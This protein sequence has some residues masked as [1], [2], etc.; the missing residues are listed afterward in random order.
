MTLGELLR[1]LHFLA[2]G[3]HRGAELDEEM[4]LHTELRARQLAV[5]G[6][7]AGHAA[8]E[9]ER[10]FG[11]RTLLRE[12]SREM[13]SFL[14]IDT[15][16]RELRLAARTLGRSPGFTLIA[17]ITLALGIGANT[18]VFSVV[19]VVLLRPLP[20]PHPEQL[21]AMMSRYDEHGQTGDDDVVD[22]RTWEL[23]R[24]HAVAVDPAIYSMSGTVNLAANGHAGYVT[25]QRVSAGFFR[26]LGVRPRLG[27]EFS[28]AED[29]PG[30]PPVVILSDRIWRTMLHADPSV[31]DRPVMLNGEPATVTGIMPPHFQSTFEADVWAPLRAT[32]Q[33]EGAGEN[34]GLVLRLKS[35]S[36]WKRAATE[37]EVIGAMRIRERRLPPGVTLSFSLVPLRKLL[38]G[39]VRTPLLILWSAVGIVL[40]IGCI[41]VAGLLLARGAG[42]AREMGTRMALGG[43]RAQ[44]VRQ[45]LVES[46]LLALLGGATGLG[47]GWAAITSFRTVVHDS[48]GIWQPIS[49]DVRVLA[50]TLALAVLT[51]VLF[52]LYP[53]FQASR[54]DIRGAL[55]E[56]GAR[57]IAGGRSLW[58]RRLMI[59]GEVALGVILLVGAGLLVRSFLYLRGQ[60]LGFDPRSL[61]A[62]TLPMQDAHYHTSAAVNHLFMETLAR[63]R[64]VPGVEGAAAV[65]ALPYERGLNTNFHLRGRESARM[66][67]LV[68]VTPAYFQVLRIPVLAGRS[69]D[70]GD[71][72]RS[73]PVVVV[74]RTFAARFL[75]GENPIGQYITMGN[76][77]RRIVGVVADVPTRGSLGGTEP[78]T[79]NP[80][81]YIPVAQVSDDLLRLI[82]VWFSPSIVVRSSAPLRDTIEGMQSAIATVDP[83]IPFSTFR[84]IEQ[85]RS[86]TLAEQQFQTALMA[87]M[88][89]LALL[90]AAI[91]IYGLIAHSVVERTR[92]MGIRL[93]LGATTRD[94]VA[95]VAAPGVALAAGGATM[96]ILCALE[97]TKVLRHMIWGVTATD[98]ATF[99]GTALLLLLVAIAA[100]L[101]PALRIVR[102]SPADTLR[103]E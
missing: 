28:R 64:A 18:A 79:V 66:T 43:G 38:S 20:W 19:D 37:V 50:V 49:L 40:L 46:L 86:E 91:G 69:P 72:P 29:T 1:R 87:I 34:F 22:G 101:I 42:R 68:Y 98:A 13:W 4:R 80:E 85:I 71:G 59:L 89:G 73:G 12:T 3:R 103:S 16:W 51:S 57:G 60:P 96:G 15:L 52:G 2:Q 67:R 76:E 24:D 97:A 6:A 78:L 7:D 92:E 30:G 53:A 55:A 63:I 56:A 77:S 81:V 48:L 54:I 93:A 41:N 21:G 17:V 102:L 14:S 90:L 23:M 8:H 95:A 27:R 32:S 36:T 84:S 61:V 94:A 100:S 82:H 25:E 45:L 99:I 74:S 10:M 47:A 70:E 44:I 39:D 9:A 35:G 26:V 83:L 88:A 33:G 62:A 75:G 65:L 58:P 31:L 11:N 5:Q